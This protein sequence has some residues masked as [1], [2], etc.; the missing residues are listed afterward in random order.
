MTLG[1]IPY[2]ISTLAIFGLV[3]IIG[4][5]LL[6]VITQTDNEMMLQ[7]DLPYSQQRATAMGWIIIGYRALAVFATICVV[8]FLIVNGNQAESGEI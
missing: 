6:D 7:H 2:A 3:L 4:G 1:A 8:V 5:Y